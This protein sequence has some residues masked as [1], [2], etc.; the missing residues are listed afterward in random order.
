MDFEM[1]PAQFLELKQS[2]ANL[3]NDVRSINRAIRGE[4]LEGNLGILKTI[5]HM[6][7]KGQKIHEEHEERIEALEKA[8]IRQRA[9]TAGASFAGSLIGAAIALISDIAGWIK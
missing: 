4:P 7:E 8:N 9:Y 6:N 3:A 1:D 5:N 2:I